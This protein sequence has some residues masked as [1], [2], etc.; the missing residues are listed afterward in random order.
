MRE[1]KQK[2]AVREHSGSGRARFLFPPIRP[3]HHSEMR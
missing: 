1:K 3:P 2:S